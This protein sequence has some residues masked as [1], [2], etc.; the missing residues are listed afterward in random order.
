M[1]D[2][3]IMSNKSILEKA[4]MT[5]QDLQTDGGLL[6][7]E[8]AGKLIRILID[9][10]VLMGQATVTPMKSPKQQMN[11]IR[12]A[13]RI[14]RAG[15]ESVALSEADRSKPDLSQVELDAKLFKAEVRLTNE[16]LE[17]SI[18]RGELRQ[19]IMEEMGLALSRDMEE[20]IVQG[21][22]ASADPTLA[23]FDG[24][25]KQVTSNI[26]N[27]GGVPANKTLWRDMLKTMPSPFLRDKRMLRFFTS[28]DAELDYRDSISD[29]QTASGDNALNNDAPVG[30]SGI[31][32]ADVPLFPENLGVGTNETV[33]ILTHPKNINVG[34]WRNIRFETDKN[35]SQ[36]VVVI[37]ATLRFDMKLIEETAAVKGIGITVA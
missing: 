18:E 14:L 3:A 23:Q 6:L 24:L 17:D 36:G 8:Q 12:F 28:N 13:S 19:T 29:R 34:I 7:P 1:A 10:S 20:I 25:I 16:S 22:T 15:Q 21:D 37:V 5:L 9:K 33:A 31:Q 32:V 2:G 30:Y 27:A 11:K 35:I 26:V 4:D